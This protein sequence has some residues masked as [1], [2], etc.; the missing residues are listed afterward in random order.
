MGRD[1]EHFKLITEWWPLVNV[2]RVSKGTW[3]R[4]IDMKPLGS[5]NIGR[6]TEF[7]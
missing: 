2:R 7:T 6:F 5:T 3:K 4:D 1:I